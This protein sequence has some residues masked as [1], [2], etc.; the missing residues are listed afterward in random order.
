MIFVLVGWRP[1][2]E[3]TQSEKYKSSL[4]FVFYFRHKNCVDI[5]EGFI[6]C[7]SFQIWFC[8]LFNR[9]RLKITSLSKCQPQKQSVV[10]FQTCTLFVIIYLPSLCFDIIIVCWGR[11]PGK[12]PDRVQTFLAKHSRLMTLFT[13]DRGWLRDFGLR[14]KS[15]PLTTENWYS[16]WFV[17]I[18]V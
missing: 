8:F 11:S 10:S 3:A 12:V 9:K 4:L 1:L 6:F 15:V 2:V 18:Y 14:T 13:F 16:K 5:V 17:Y 7:L